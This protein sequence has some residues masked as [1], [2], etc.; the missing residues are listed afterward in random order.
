MPPGTTCDA[1]A[2]TIDVLP[3]IAKLIGAD[4]PGHRIDGQDITPLLFGTSTTSPHALYCCYY[5]GGQLQAVRD[6]RWKLHFPHGYQTLEGR[7]GGTNGE[8]VSYASRE[9]E[10]SLFDLASDPGETTN[11]AAANPDVVARLQ[12]SADAARADLGDSLRDIKGTGVR[13]AGRLAESATGDGKGDGK[14]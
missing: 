2:A 14:R 7:R 6:G 3:T 8:P 4:L 11:V 1:F 5:A 10:L 12:A 13:P 9:I